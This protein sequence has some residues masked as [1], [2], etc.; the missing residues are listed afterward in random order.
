MV[1]FHRDSCRH[2][3]EAKKRHSP[4]QLYLPHPQAP[5]PHFRFGEKLGLEKSLISGLEKTLV[6]LHIH[7]TVLNSSKMKL[8]TCASTTWGTQEGTVGHW[9][10]PFVVHS[11]ITSISD[12]WLEH[13]HYWP[14]PP[15]HQDVLKGRKEQPS[16]GW[17]EMPGAQEQS[18][19]GGMLLSSLL[20]SSQHHLQLQDWHRDLPPHRTVGWEEETG[21]ISL[22]SWWILPGKWLL[23]FNSRTTEVQPIYS[24]Q[25][26]DL[27]YKE[28][29]IFK[30]N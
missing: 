18:R 20:G 22:S 1:T 17:E 2:C 16:Q 11:S 29:I 13:A 25:D 15:W 8:G 12:P 3:L 21:R 28:Y 27:F 14:E 5:A 4:E 19:T 24:H 23:N 9:H 6:P 10:Y 7:R 30:C 26:Y